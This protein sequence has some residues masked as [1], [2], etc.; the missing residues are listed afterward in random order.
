[1]E[2]RKLND[3]E[4]S[5]SN[6]NEFSGANYFYFRITFTKE[7]S[8]VSGFEISTFGVKKIKFRKL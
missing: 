2:H 1:M 5:Q 6:E 8:V 4:L 7:E 3:I